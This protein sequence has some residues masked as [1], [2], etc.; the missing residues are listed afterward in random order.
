MAIKKRRDKKSAATTRSKKKPAKV[1]SA[2]PAF[3]SV[4]KFTKL[5][6]MTRRQR[7]SVARRQQA[8]PAESR[9]TAS[10]DLDL[11]SGFDPY[12]DD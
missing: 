9:A 4:Q 5:R 11:T 3:L 12:E 8:A 10:P 1:A 7:I 6:E 2:E